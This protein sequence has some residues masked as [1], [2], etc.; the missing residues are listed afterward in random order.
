MKSIIFSL[1]LLLCAFHMSFAQ[2]RTD[3]YS[4]VQVDTILHGDY[5]IRAL[6]IDGSTLYYGA[7]KSR[8]GYINVATEERMEFRYEVEDLEFRSIAK[9]RDHIFALNAGS[10]AVLTKMNKDG[11]ELKVVYDDYNPKVFYDSMQFWNNYEGIAVGDPLKGCMAI[12][13][14][15]DGGKNWRR[16]PCSVLPPVIEGEAA[17]A[18]S[19]TNIVVK[20]DRTWIVT[21]GA[22]SRILY[23]PD[24][25][26]S[27]FLSD[28][29]IV[30]G[31]STTGI[32]SADFY[33]FK[34]GFI[35]GGDY[36]KPEMNN[37][38]KAITTDGGQTWK[39]VA[40]NAGFG[41][42]SCVQFVPDGDGAQLVTVGPSGLQ[43]SSDYGKTW[44]QLYADP[45]LYTI[46][47]QNSRTAY[48]AGKNKIIKIT[49]K[50]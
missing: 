22:V 16:L 10:P 18:A 26:K 2:N 19:N 34:Y 11:S 35:V 17:F 48:A 4:E 36:T 13:I 43:Y 20:G 42:A 24:K 46:R 5:S 9:T 50:N 30:S 47:F 45:S 12:V 32:Y 7:D 1:F 8:I 6:L 28:T 37:Q 3:I 25:G 31:Q 49:F 23:S 14:T 40:D 33:D 15:R 21:G 41:Y 29:P 27:W 39:T 44:T 38:N